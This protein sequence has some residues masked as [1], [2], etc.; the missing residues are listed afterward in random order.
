MCVAAYVALFTG[1][2]ITFGAAVW[3]R[4]MVILLCVVMMVLLLART[5]RRRN[6]LAG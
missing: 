5:I 1:F 4:E 3:L 2:G 6:D